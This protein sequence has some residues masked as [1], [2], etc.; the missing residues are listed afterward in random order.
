MKAKLTV[1]GTMVVACAAIQLTAM[2]T[3]K[4]AAASTKDVVPNVEYKFSYKLENGMAIITGIEPK[5][6][7]TL[8]IPDKIDGHKVTSISG[9][10][11]NDGSPFWS[12]CEQMTKI[13]LP[14]GLEIPEAFCNCKSLSSIEISKSNKKFASRDGVLYSK[15][16]STLFAYPK[17]RESVK[18]S[19][20]TRKI[21]GCAFRGCALKT[22]KIPEGIVEVEP[23]NLCECPD[24][25]WIEF[26][27]SLKYLGQCAACGSGKL[28][29]IVF[30]GNAPQIGLGQF[31]WGRQYVF[32][33]APK[34]L[35][36]EVRKGTKGWKSPGSRELPECWPT[37]QSESRPIRYIK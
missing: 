14:A 26:P 24:L 1:I 32:T 27:K 28:K 36:V 9:S 15:D 30:N 21:G 4:R 19:S 17:T 34:D 13:V 29:K 35:V 18:L 6:V 33:G 20:K 10:G 11:Y 23:W 3:E 12:G 8:V 25:E 7:G 22:A 16:F 37:N 5:P 2:P 31:S